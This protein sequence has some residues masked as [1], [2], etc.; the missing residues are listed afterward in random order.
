MN[1]SKA[2][3]GMYVTLIMAVLQILGVDIDEGTVTEVI[4]AG[5]TVVSAIVWI[6]GQ[7]SRSDLVLGLMRR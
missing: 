5:I 3:V 2:G 1:V 7:L 6:Y 4:M